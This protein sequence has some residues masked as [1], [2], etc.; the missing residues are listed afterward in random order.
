MN[1]LVYIIDDDLVSQFATQYRIKQSIDNCM[2]INFD[3]AQEGLRAFTDQLTDGEQL[4]DILILDLKMPEMDGWE[5]LKEFSNIHRPTMPTDI[6]VLSSFANKEVWR[7]AAE[8]PLVKECFNK[9][10]TKMDVEKIRGNK[11]NINTT[12]S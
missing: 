12:L 7:K 1:S 11:Q 10:M 2:F 8:H 5:F 3:S 6:Y 9:P 4:P